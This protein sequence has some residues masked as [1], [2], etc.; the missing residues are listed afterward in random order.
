LSKFSP[1]NKIFIEEMERRRGLE[2]GGYDRR[3]SFFPSSRKLINVNHPKRKTRNY[4]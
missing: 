3:G 1:R 4:L 2:E